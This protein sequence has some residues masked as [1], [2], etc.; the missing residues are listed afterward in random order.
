M[1]GGL[2]VSGE[3]EHWVFFL[4]ENLSKN[5]HVHAI[6]KIIFPTNRQIQ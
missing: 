3:K 6:I 5:T 4:N 1:V 2:T